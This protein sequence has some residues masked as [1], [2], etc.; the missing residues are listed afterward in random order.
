MFSC[1]QGRGGRLGHGNE[2]TV[3]SPK[4][5]TAL[6]GIFCTDVSSANDHTLI[7]D[8]MGQ[9]HSFGLNAYHQLGHNPVPS[10]CLTPKLV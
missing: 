9:V 10:Q 2:Q 7:L 4:I 8:Q 3:L 6:K 1:G 5:I